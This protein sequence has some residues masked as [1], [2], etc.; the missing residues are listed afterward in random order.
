MMN[1]AQ[2]MASQAFAENPNARVNTGINPMAD[3]LGALAQEQMQLQGRG[4]QQPTYQTGGINPKFNAVA[5]GVAGDIP[6]RNNSTY[7]LV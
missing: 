3:P 1:M 6:A 4:V 5:A 2:Q 7:D